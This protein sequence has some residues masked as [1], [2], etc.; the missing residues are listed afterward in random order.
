MPVFSSPLCV[1]SLPATTPAVLTAAHSTTPHSS[2][3]A[4]FMPPLT[5]ALHLF[6]MGTVLL[7]LLRRQERNRVPLCFDAGKQECAFGLLQLIHFRLD[8]RKVRLSVIPLI[9]RR[10]P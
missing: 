1:A 9:D 5:A 8:G 6:A 4:A 10:M 3:P 7:S 2:H